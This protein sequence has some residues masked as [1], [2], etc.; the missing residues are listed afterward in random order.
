MRAQPLEQCVVHVVRIAAC[1]R[2][3]VGVGERHTLARIERTVAR[4]L[5]DDGVELL[6]R[7]SSFAADGSVD[8]LSEET[9][10]VRGNPAIDERLELHVDQAEL[11]E[12]APHA[13]H[14][15]KERG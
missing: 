3:C 10:V 14:A 7:E 5:A 4:E 6:V 11:P 1:Q 15:T 8:V 12:R 9:P 13:T 2:H